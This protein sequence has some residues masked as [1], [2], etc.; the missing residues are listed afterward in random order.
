MK[1]HKPPAVAD[2]TTMRTGG[3]KLVC[4]EYLPIPRDIQRSLRDFDS[5]ERQAER[6]ST[7]VN[8]EFM[9]LLHFGFIDFVDDYSHSK[10]TRLLLNARKVSVLAIFEALKRYA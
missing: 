8:G 3:T 7:S 2:V 1:D 5:R 10:Q 6:T 9:S 4:A